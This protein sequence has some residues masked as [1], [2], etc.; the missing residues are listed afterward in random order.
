MWFYQFLETISI[1]QVKQKLHLQV[2]C[3]FVPPEFQV[4]GCHGIF[5]GDMV[6]WDIYKAPTYHI[7]ETFMEP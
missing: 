7:D 6:T 4:Q 2:P 5:Q 3:Y 1:L